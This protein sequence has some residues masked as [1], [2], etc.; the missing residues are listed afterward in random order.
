MG[1]TG[2]H[3]LG[4]NIPDFIVEIDLRPRCSDYFPSPRSSQDDEL[5]RACSRAFLR[6]KIFHERRCLGIRQCGMMAHGSYFRSL[7]KDVVEMPAPPRW[8]VAAAI[9]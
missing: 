2:F 7:R 9:S 5:E 6:A 3:S 8:I 1:T 4:R